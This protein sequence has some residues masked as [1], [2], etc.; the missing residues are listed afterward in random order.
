VEDRAAPLVA[1][2]VADPGAGRGAGRPPLPVAAPPP[3]ALPAAIV[4]AHPL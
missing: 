2:R 4:S 3:L 1:L